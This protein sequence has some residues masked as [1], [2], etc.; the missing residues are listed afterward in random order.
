MSVV[1][2]VA[3]GRLNQDDIGRGVAHAD[4]AQGQPPK[5]VKEAVAPS[6]P[7]VLSKRAAS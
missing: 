6:P 5:P 1:V 4:N 2:L 3:C 7:L